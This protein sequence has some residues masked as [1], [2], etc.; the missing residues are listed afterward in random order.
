MDDPKFSIPPSIAR[1]LSLGACHAEHAI[2]VG[3]RAG[4]IQWAHEAW[5]RATRYAP[6]HSLSKP[7]LTSPRDG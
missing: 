5:R 4:V 3:N 2:V 1:K 7:A 6:E